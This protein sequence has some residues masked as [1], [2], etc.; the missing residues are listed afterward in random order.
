MCRDYTRGVPSLVA[1]ATASLLNALSAS[2]ALILSFELIV[3]D[4]QVEKRKFPK[5]WKLVDGLKFIRFIAA[6]RSPRWY[7]RAVV[8]GFASVVTQTEKRFTEDK[9]FTMKGP[10]SFSQTNTDPC[11][12][13]PT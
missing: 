13:R 11:R 8:K 3:T 10:L 4:V 6:S 12:R 5:Q 2:S 9:C 1:M 7:C